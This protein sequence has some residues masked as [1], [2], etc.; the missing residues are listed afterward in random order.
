MRKIKDQFEILSFP[1]Y[2]HREK[3]IIRKVQSMDRSQEQCEEENIFCRL[4]TDGTET[5]CLEILKSPSDGPKKIVNIWRRSCQLISHAQL[6]WNGNDGD[7]TID[8]NHFPPLQFGGRRKNGR[9]NL[10]S[11]A[12]KKEPQ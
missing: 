6:R 5:K 11:F 2:L 9:N 7:G 3:R 8:L 10:C 12:L 4:R 1:C